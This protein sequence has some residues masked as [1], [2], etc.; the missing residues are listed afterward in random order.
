MG[1]I[2]K[3]ENPEFQEEIEKQT[4]DDHSA[5][6]THPVKRLSKNRKRKRRREKTNKHSC[7]ICNRTFTRGYTLAKHV[8][9]IHG[10]P[11][12]CDHCPKIFNDKNLLKSHMQYHRT[13]KFT[14]N[15]C[16]FRS[17]MIHDLKKH[18]I[19]HNLK[20]KCKICDKQVSSLKLHLRTAHKAK[21]A[22]L[23]CGKMIAENQMKK[24]LGIHDSSRLK[25]KD[26]DETFAKHIDLRR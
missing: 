17:A 20:E 18:K 14:C 6:T 8:A 12:F 13:K 4:F 23:I 5:V 22:C 26:C 7:K 19:I 21:K 10:N 1:F 25:C 3:V 9:D 2:I 24:H 15:I 11:M 16:G